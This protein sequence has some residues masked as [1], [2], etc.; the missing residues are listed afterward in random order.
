VAQAYTPRYSESWFEAIWAKSSQPMA[1][2]SGV[3]LSSQLHREGHIGC[4]WLGGWP[5]HKARLHLKNNQHKKGLV[6]WLERYSFC[7]TT[8]KPWVHHTAKKLCVIYFVVHM[9]PAFPLGPNGQLKECMFWLFCIHLVGCFWEGYLFVFW[10]CLYF[11]TLQ[12]AL[13]SSCIFPGWAL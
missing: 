3:P 10:A 11:L 6:A 4:S 8:V 2:H 7:R 5:W 13:G 1:G 9:I 12:N